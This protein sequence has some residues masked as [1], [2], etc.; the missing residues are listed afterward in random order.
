VGDEVKPLALVSSRLGGLIATID[1]AQ[2]A[3]DDLR[4][5]VPA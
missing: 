4:A 3:T 2:V 1:E 5:S